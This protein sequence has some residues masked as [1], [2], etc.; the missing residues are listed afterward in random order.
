MAERAKG[1]AK[2]RKPKA[3]A[4]GAGHNSTLGLPGGGPPDE[5]KLRWLGKVNTAEAAYDKSAEATKK[6]KSQL[7]NVYAGAKDDGCDI[8]ALKQA[9]RLDKRAHADVA[10]E[11]SATGDW[12]RLMKSPLSEQLELFRTPDWPEPVNANLQG[13][14]VGRAGG[15]I[16][17]CQ[18]QPGSETF[19]SWKTGYDLGQEEN[20]ESLRNA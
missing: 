10:A 5:V 16:D 19:A 2:K 18:Y 4:N 14:R 6:L 3:K 11:Y 17:E 1:S 12:L 15:S 8:D 9:R 7:S 13:Y 20:R